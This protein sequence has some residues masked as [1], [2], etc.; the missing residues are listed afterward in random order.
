[1]NRSLRGPLPGR[2]S[3]RLEPTKKQLLLKKRIFVSSL[4]PSPGGAPGGENAR[5]KGQGGGRPV[6]FGAWKIEYSLRENDGEVESRIG[7]LDQPRRPHE[8]S[9]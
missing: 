9:L 1:M 3:Q 5:D 8:G 7:R 4:S 6:G 2:E